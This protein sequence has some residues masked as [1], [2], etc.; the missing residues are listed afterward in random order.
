MTQ[1]ALKDALSQA[2]QSTDA[3]AALTTIAAD[4]VPTTVIG[5]EFFLTESGSLLYREFFESSRSNRDLLHS[6]WFDR[7]VSFAVSVGDTRLHGYGVPT[8]THVAGPLFQEHYRIVTDRD[9]RT[10]LAAVWE[11]RVDSLED[12]SPQLLRSKEDTQRPF[13][14]HLDRLIT[15]EA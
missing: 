4:G 10:D 14:R 15:P 5:A 7:I 9:Q 1:N 8:H 11:I 6:L 12:V 13:F 2:L 3:V